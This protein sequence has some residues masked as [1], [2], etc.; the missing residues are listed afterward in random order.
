MRTLTP[1]TNRRRVRGHARPTPMAT[2]HSMTM[3]E[4]RSATKPNAVGCLIVTAVSCATEAQ[5]AEHSFQRHHPGIA[6]RVVVVDDRFGEASRGRANW[7]PFRGDVREVVRLAM[8]H[9]TAALKRSLLPSAAMATMT[10]LGVEHLIV[11]P[12]DSETLRPL[13][14]DA[15][16]GTEG[17]HVFRVRLNDPPGDGRLPDQ[18]NELESG[19]VDQQFFVAAGSTGRAVLKDW[20]SKLVRSPLENSDH[21][22]AVDANWLDVLALRRGDVFVESPCVGS[23]RNVDELPFDEMAAFRFTG[24]RVDRPWILSSLAGEWPRAILSEFPAIEE[25]VRA[26]TENLR[27]ATHPVL[28][29]PYGRLPNGHRVDSVMR[30]VYRSQLATS[31]RE[32]QPEP[33]NPFVAGEAQR[34]T[35]WLAEPVDGALSR[36]LLALGRA[37]PDIQSLF[38]NDQTAFELWAT[39]DAPR[40]G[41]WVPQTSYSSLR[42]R[43]GSRTR[44]SPTEAKSEPS[45]MRTEIRE[46]I[47]DASG[48]NVVGLLS[49]QLGVGESGRLTLRTLNDSR[50]PFSLVDHDATVSERD[51]SLVSNFIDRPTGFPFDVDLLLINADQTA[52]ALSSLGRGGKHERPTI[53]VWA[54]EVQTFPERMHSAFALVDEVWALSDFTRDAIQPAASKFGVRVHTFPMRLPEV[55][56]QV[57]PRK[58]SESLTALGLPVGVP[59][60]AFA[61]D[62]FSVAERKQPWAVVD[63]FGRAFPGE[64]K[65]GPRL[66]IKSINHEF[67]PTD[68]ER[69]LHAVGGRSDII[70]IERY[71]PAD[72]RDALIRGA[73]AYVS[74]HRAEGFGL[75]LAE[76]MSVGTP[77]ISTGWSGNLQFMNDQNSFLVASQLVDIAADTPVYAGLGQ[78]AE[79]DLDIAAQLMRGVLEDPEQ[80]RRKAQQALRD[81]EQHNNSGVDV[82]FLLARLRAV[83]QRST[84]HDRSPFSASGHLTLQRS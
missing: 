63:A 75:T 23:Y 72:Q 56:A 84:V 3:S 62:Y 13:P 37:R 32:G 9:D 47:S 14:L 67:R 60:F 66:V 45:T 40:Q 68:R 35:E 55:P 20:R 5:L 31:A 30:S 38:A 65:N 28:Q 50:V 39:R 12:D 44:V 4:Q 78:W 76:A 57:D 46:C 29:N 8:S 22:D 81:V 6:L 16:F 49:A 69:L 80:A 24:F 61:F 42:H 21:F 19:T 54:W 36:Y 15:L 58:T 2:V 43:V 79:P 83:R 59:F 10:E 71:L 1:A 11:L 34:F 26:R 52:Q 17:L 70:L 51:A 64:E 73:V 18:R 77:T 74:L 53:A 7:G 48:V 41:I 27:S 82:A 25:I 33:P